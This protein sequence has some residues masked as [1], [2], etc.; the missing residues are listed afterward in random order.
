MSK[1]LV[2]LAKRSATISITARLM[3]PLS[4]LALLEVGQLRHYHLPNET[5]IENNTEATEITIATIESLMVVL[6]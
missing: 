2:W 4:P 6:S 3:P 5:E 1:K